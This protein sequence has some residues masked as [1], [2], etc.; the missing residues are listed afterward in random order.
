MNKLRSFF[1]HLERGKKYFTICQYDDGI[2]GDRGGG[3]YDIDCIVF[4][5]G[6]YGDIP[7]PLV[8]DEH[9]HKEVK[10][11]K[12]LA[13]FLGSFRTEATE[14]PIRPQIAKVLGDNDAFLIEDSYG[15]GREAL[16]RFVNVTASSY[17]TLCPR[18]YGKTSYRLYEAMQLGSVPVYISDEHWLPFT[19]YLSWSDFAIVIK[20]DMIEELPKLL[21]GIL[22]EGKYSQMR[23]NAFKAYREFFVY[24]SCFRMITRILEE[25]YARKR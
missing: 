23:Q 8:C 6:G 4:G 9:H 18:G 10:W 19:K 12:Y 11:K 7:I 16:E 14:F 21:M 1:N 15:K 2:L 5:A 25:E 3:H 13:S 24:D 20:P 22:E 17:F